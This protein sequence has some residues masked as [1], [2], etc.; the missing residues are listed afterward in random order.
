MLLYLLLTTTLPLDLPLN[1]AVDYLQI[2]GFLDIQVIKP[3]DFNYII[4][5]IDT[6]FFSEKQLNK[7]DKKFISLFG[8]YLGKSSDFYT[9]FALS[10]KNQNFKDFFGDFDLHLSGSISDNISFSQA[11]RFHAGS[12][13]DS[14]GPQP[15][16][17]VVQAYLNEGVLNITSN[18]KNATLTLGRRN[19]SLGLEDMSSL[20]LSPAKEGY[21]GF[22]FLYNGKY[23][24]FFSTFFVLDVEQLRFIST[25]R[26]G[27]NLNNIR[28]GFAEAILWAGELE[29]LYLNFFLP[30]YLSQWGIKRNDNIMWCIDASAHFSNTLIFGEFL[31]DD[32][33]FSE[34]PEGYTEYPHKLAFQ[35]GLRKILLERIYTRFNY[36]F[37]DKWVYTH[38]INANVY[39]K[40]SI[41]LGFSLGNDVDNFTLELKHLSDNLL[42][43]FLKLGY[44]RKGEGSIFLPYEVERGPAYPRFP[45]GIV[46]KRFVIKLGI[47]FYFNP[48]FYFSIEAGREFY[49]NYEHTQGNKKQENLFDARFWI[50]L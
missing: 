1:Q 32:Y 18:N 26:I 23:Y 36:T 11:I 21:D 7:I 6:L 16:K 14:A 45:S 8:P 20:L 48:R 41:P 22:L 25:H 28:L 30:Y 2:R 44:T 40:D 13:I 19:I 5:G 50:L 37:V 3:I 38:R 43:P 34:P 49:E 46:E 47:E 27:L 42:I 39:A 35:F 12:K 10:G 17:D 33:Q 29:P 24:E 31:I 9:I 15:Y 4:S